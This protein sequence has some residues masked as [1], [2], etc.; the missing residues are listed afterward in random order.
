M[1]KSIEACE[2][3]PYEPVQS[4]SSKAST[5]LQYQPACFGL[6][7]IAH[8]FGAKCSDGL[9]GIKTPIVYLSRRQHPINVDEYHIRKHSEL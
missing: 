5:V 2:H 4:C 7:R 8:I 1:A 3:L 9:S 6:S